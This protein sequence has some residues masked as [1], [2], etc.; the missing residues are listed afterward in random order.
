MA[1]VCLGPAAG[2]KVTRGGISLPV[3]ER[4]GG[5]RCRIRSLVGAVKKFFQN[6]LAA[7][8]FGDNGVMQEP[9]WNTRSEVTNGSLIFPAGSEL[10]HSQPVCLLVPLHFF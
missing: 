6:W 1:K 7:A 3:R 9:R 5:I 4:A 2:S 10:G 8:D